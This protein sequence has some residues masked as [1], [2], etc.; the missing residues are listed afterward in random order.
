MSLRVN[1]ILTNILSK[2]LRVGYKK[3]F[4]EKSNVLMFQTFYHVI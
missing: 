4:Q 2:V 3:V 1:E